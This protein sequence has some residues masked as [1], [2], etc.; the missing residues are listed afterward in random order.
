VRAGLRFLTVERPGFGISDF[1]P[2]RQLLDWPG[3]IEQFASELDL[4]R[5]LL[6]G[7]SGGGPYVAACAHSIPARIDAAAIV[8]GFGPMNA[9]AIEGMAWSRRAAVGLVRMLPRPMQ[10][11]ADTLPLQRHPE[12][13]YRYMMRA[14]PREVD[15]LADGWEDRMADVAEALRPGLRGFV[16]E[17]QIVT[18][19]WGFRLEDIRAPVHVWHGEADQATPISM[20]RQMAR[21]IPGCQAHFI[22]NAGHLLWK[23]HQE[24][25]V[26]AMVGPR[27]T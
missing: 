16:Q 22:P 19:D 26:A 11:I 9:D 8:A 23:S 3:N 2:N 1:Q 4:S 17:L 24:E 12:L 13:I 14:M 25:I 15:L 20:G 5:F 18:G 7:T 6:V 21:R 10:W 27:R